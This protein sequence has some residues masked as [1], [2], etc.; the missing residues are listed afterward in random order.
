M[1][2]MRRSRAPTSPRAERNLAIV[3][4]AVGLLGIVT[5]IG[6]LVLWIRFTIGG[7]N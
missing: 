1:S 5:V 4:N 3:I 2:T 7:N 6:L